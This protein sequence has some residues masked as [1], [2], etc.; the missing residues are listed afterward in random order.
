MQ[1]D[2]RNYKVL[3][4][5]FIFQNYFL[6]SNFIFLLAIDITDENGSTGLQIASANGHV[7]NQAVSKIMTIV[8]F[9]IH[10]MIYI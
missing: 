1:K 7:S 8:T 6:I 2:A 9:D 5:K 3:L 4:L 10:C